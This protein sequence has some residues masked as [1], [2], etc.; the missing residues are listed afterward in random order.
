[1]RSNWQRRPALRQTESEALSTI[2]GSSHDLLNVRVR[3]KDSSQ[4]QGRFATLGNRLYSSTRF[5]N[6]S[7]TQGSKGRHI[8]PPVERRLDSCGNQQAPLASSKPVHCTLFRLALVC[9]HGC[10]IRFALQRGGD[11]KKNSFSSKQV[12]TSYT[13]LGAAS[14]GPCCASRWVPALRVCGDLCAHGGNPELTILDTLH[15]SEIKN[16]CRIMKSA[17]KC[18]QNGGKEGVLLGGF[19]SD[20]K[21]SR[22]QSLLSNQLLGEQTCPVNLFH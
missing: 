14:H 7:S 2:M 11:E 8:C 3:L 12:R 6:G 18:Q 5:M 1:M 13:V 21:M 4:A 17:R 10:L 9:A 20:H 19:L 16:P 22:S 15:N